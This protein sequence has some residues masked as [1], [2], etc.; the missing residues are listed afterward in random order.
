MGRFCTDI[1]SLRPSTDGQTGIQTEKTD[2]ILVEESREGN[3]EAYALL[4]HRHARRIYALC[5]GM[6]GN[7]TDSEDMVQETFI[8]GLTHIRSLRD[9]RQFGGWI[10]QI[11]RNMCRDLMRKRNRRTRLLDQQ[12]LP[13]HTER[14]DF[15]DLHLALERLPEK[16]R[17]PLLLYYFDGKSSKKLAEELHCTTITTEEE[18]G[19]LMDVV[20][21]ENGDLDRE[22]FLVEVIDGEQVVTQVLP[23]LGTSC[24]EQ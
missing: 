6:L 18:P 12:P 14:E 7:V 8:K 2:E 9:N 1:V 24:G 19:V 21:D 4:V 11:A 5:L 16:Y 22:S 15:S 3:R 20:Y 23:R 10:A 13:E 17:L